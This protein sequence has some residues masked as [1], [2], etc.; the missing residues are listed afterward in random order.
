MLTVRRKL[1]RGTTPKSERVIHIDPKFSL[2]RVTDETDPRDDNGKLKRM[3]VQEASQRVRVIQVLAKD[4]EKKKKV[5]EMRWQTFSK[6]AFN[7]FSF[8]VN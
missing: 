1:Q 5:R 7:S 6:F 3:T 4:A 2:R 8:A